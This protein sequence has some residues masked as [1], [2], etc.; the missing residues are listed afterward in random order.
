MKTTLYSLFVASKDELASQLGGL[1]LPSGEQ[2]VQS[3]VVK[4]FNKIFDADGD[5]R[6]NLTQSEDYILQAALSML[7]MQQTML[8]ELIPA[9]N[10]RP[11]M[12]DN[13]SKS[14]RLDSSKVVIGQLLPLGGSALGGTTGA[15][16]FGTWGAVFGA[17]AGTAVA[18]YF[19]A[20][21]QQDTIE[22]DYV[23]PSTPIEKELNV[24]AFI[25]IIG[26]ICQSVDSLIDTFRAQ[27]N[28]V[29]SKYE[30]QE[31]ATL[32]KDFRFLLE[33]IQSLV[34]YKRTHSEDEPKYIRKL[35]ERIE[36]VGELLENYNLA[37]VDYTEDNEYM[38]EVVEGQENRMV[39]PAI[40]KNGSV[41][42]KGKIF[43]KNNV[44]QSL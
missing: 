12:L 36:D 44:N 23:S 35:K 13:T 15:L 2:E 4:Y 9:D 3:C 40:V 26:K 11:I 16:L 41:V 17:I 6:Q 42:L 31:K 29:V 19:S 28:R 21:M 10:N 14:T 30:S 5:F 39:L 8:G 25:D 18:M 32:E 22:A 20:R 1:T 24:D 7:T 43:K 37:V 27:I 38:F 34:G 33:G